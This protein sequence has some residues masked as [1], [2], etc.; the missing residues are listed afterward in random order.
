M[1]PKLSA[2]FLILLL[3]PSCSCN[4]M[5][6][7]V[8][9]YLLIQALLEVPTL[10]LIKETLTRIAN[11]IIREELGLA[12]DNT[13]SF[14]LP[15]DRPYE[16]LTLYYIDKIDERNQTLI[17][18]ALDDLQKNTPVHITE[19]TL[20]PH[21]E[22][23]GNQLNELVIMIGDRDGQLVALNHNITNLMHN[24]NNTY[25][26]NH[27]ADLY[28]II[29][30]ERFPFLPHVSLGKI[31]LIAIGNHIKKASQIHKTLARIKERIKKEAVNIIHPMLTANNQNISS[32]TMGL[33]DLKKQSMIKEYK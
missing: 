17:L 22:F 18:S 21:V 23:F 24:L 7:P 26:K 5:R 15:K 30:S 28:D 13:Y 10:T 12:Q 14:F 11:K 2:I 9:Q 1:L 29:K 20:L 25:K 3:L 31:R 8:P 16:Q 27:N 33:F 19:A 4:R 6:D 32:K